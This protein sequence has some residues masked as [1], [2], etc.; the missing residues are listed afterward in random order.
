LANRV[1]LAKW[2][3]DILGIDLTTNFRL[4]SEWLKEKLNPNKTGA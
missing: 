3:A 1:I 4:S 2:V